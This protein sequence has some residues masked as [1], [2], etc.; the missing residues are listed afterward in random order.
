M[1][2]TFLFVRMHKKYVFIAQISKK[3]VYVVQI[4]KKCEFVAQIPKKCEFVVQIPKNRTYSATFV[5]EFFCAKN[6]LE[7]ANSSLFSA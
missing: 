4:P 2:D 7:Q 5:A 3:C 6:L 1:F